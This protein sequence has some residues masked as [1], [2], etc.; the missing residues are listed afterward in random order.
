MELEGKSQ[1]RCSRCFKGKQSRHCSRSPHEQQ[2]RAS[3][4]AHSGWDSW[5][6][7]EGEQQVMAPRSSQHRLSALQGSAGTNL[8]KLNTTARMK[9]EPG[10]SPRGTAGGRCNWLPPGPRSITLATLSWQRNPQA[11]M[12]CCPTPCWCIFGGRSRPFHGNDDRIT[13]QIQAPP[14]AG[15]SQALRTLYP[16]W[17][18]SSQAAKS[19]HSLRRTPEG[20]R[21]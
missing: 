10:Q 14:G 21:S 15:S 2:Q 6:G 4:L 7:C 19:M 18:L 13:A 1:G 16:T 12:N 3:A 8:P 5:E 17:E 11:P 9:R 20:C